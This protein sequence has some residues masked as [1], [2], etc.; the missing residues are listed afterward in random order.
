[1]TAGF[2]DGGIGTSGRPEQL[3]SR[4]WCTGVDHDWFCERAILVPKNE[5]VQV[6]NWKL[7]QSINTEKKNYFSVDTVVDL[8]EVVNYPTEFLNSLDPREMLSP[9]LTLKKGV[10]IMLLRNLNPPKLCNGTT[11]IIRQMHPHLLETTI[12][13][14]QGKGENVFIPRIPLIPADM[15]SEFKELQF[16]GR[17]NFAMSINKCQE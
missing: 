1:M 10:P 5:T 3:A 12:L 7:M 17:V 4:S 13:T 15:P 14:G 8:N 11:L 16:P 6:V 2:G 9:K